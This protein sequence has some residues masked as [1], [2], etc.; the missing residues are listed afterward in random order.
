MSLLNIKLPGL[1]PRV[2]WTPVHIA[3]MAIDNASSMKSLA[4]VIPQVVHRAVVYVVHF[5]LSDASVCR[6]H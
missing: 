2:V 5:L 3:C 6:L 1:L 4:D